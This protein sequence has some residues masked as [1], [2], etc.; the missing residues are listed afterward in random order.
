MAT[1]IESQELPSSLRSILDGVRLRIRLYVLLQGLGLAL[2][3]LGVTFWIALGVD[4]LPVSMGLTDLPWQARAFMLAIIGGVAAWIF[5]RWIVRRIFVPLPDR[6]MAM[7]LERQFDEFH[8]SLV[9]TVE[10]NKPQTEEASFDVRML[11]ATREQANRVLPNAR[12][13]QVFNPRPLLLSWGGAAIVMLTI[14]LFAALAP[15]RFSLAGER[16]Y[17]LSSTPWPRACHLAEL[18]V[19][20]SRSYDMPGIPIEL[21]QPSFVNGKLKIGEGTSLDL[22]VKAEAPSDDQPDRRLPTVCVLSYRTDEGVRGSETMQA[23]GAQVRGLQTYQYSGAPFEGL[24]DDIDL[25]IRG[26]DHRV[27]RQS[28][29]IVDNPA[30]VRTEID[31]VFPEYMVDEA[32]GA[33][34]P[35]K[36]T[37]PSGVELPIGTQV[38]LR[39]ETNKPLRKVFVHHLEEEN[40]YSFDV[41]P[42]QSNAPGFELELPTIS[43]SQTIEFALLDV[44]GVL[45]ASLIRIEL[46]AIKD[47]PPKPRHELIGIGLAVT[48]DVMIPII[49][50]VE[51]DYGIDEAWLEIRGSDIDPIA[52]TIEL[53]A[54]NK[55][56]YLV[57]FREKQRQSEAPVKL[58]AGEGHS[59]SLTLKAVDFYNL[60]GPPK[61]GSAET[62]ELDVVTPSE[63]LRILERAEVGQRQRLDQIFDEMT[64][65]QLHLMR[66]RI[67]IQDSTESKA[68]ADSDSQSEPGPDANNPASGNIADDDSPISANELKLL[69]SRRALM[70]SR[71]SAGE[72]KGV[73]ESFI[74]IRLQLIN[75]RVDSEERK[76]RLKEFVADPLQIIIDDRFPQLFEE[77]EA[78]EAKL[79]EL[80]TNSE[81]QPLQLE[82]NLAAD[83]SIRQT[84]LI[85][86][87]LD[88]VLGKLIKYESY[89][90]LLDLFR[91]V[92]EDQEQ[93]LKDTENERKKQGLRDL[94]DQ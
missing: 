38:T 56:D 41:L 54:G 45:S 71:K 69:F 79:D 91:D 27:T 93:I 40:S 46:P 48:P 23:D 92:I 47:Q 25:N 52:E 88:Q 86:A 61:T 14:I 42:S 39:C 34:T 43:A 33:W 17:L 85:L 32:S 8:D 37:Y 44:D 50:N 68:S 15:E 5:Y 89:G 80:Q 94:I 77:I 1:L 87:E 31:C 84:Q 19:N 20:R 3:W 29:E 49:G 30:I 60:D 36:L 59:I 22:W 90:E 21:D 28:I 83:E 53:E 64:E 16:I 11:E 63:L 75:N 57:D 72:L 81:D 78:L 58:V 65:A 55:V 24:V 13:N 66:T 2:A 67:E 26:G 4:Y 82:I 10:L 76:R 51:D 74:D 62:I 9:T 7:L 70:Q 6:S 35:R 73:V 18:G 12:I